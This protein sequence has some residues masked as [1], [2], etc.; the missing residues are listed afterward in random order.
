MVDIGRVY[1]TV[2]SILNKE[3]RGYLGKDEFNQFAE[4]AQAEIYES[5]FYELARGVAQY[6]RRHE[7]SNSADHVLEKL[8]E[9]HTNFDVGEPVNDFDG[10]LPSNI[11]RLETVLVRASLDSP[12]I[13]AMEKSHAEAGYLERSL[14]TRGTIDQPFF[15]REG[16]F[17]EIFAADAPS[18][19]DVR[20]EYYRVPLEPEWN[21]T[22]FQGQLIEGNSV[23]FDLHPSEEPELVAKILAYAGVS[24]RAIDVAQAATQKDQSIMQNEQ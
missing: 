18:S 19:S 9:F 21:G 13:P 23:D 11:Y 10:S 15:T 4:Q 14:L 6:G 24:V 22:T 16:T 20:I 7:V 5:Y 3:Q 8:Q 12:F 2:L 17:I 1:N